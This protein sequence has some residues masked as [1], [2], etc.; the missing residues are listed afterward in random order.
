M[1][2][3]S[4]IMSPGNNRMKV[5]HQWTMRGQARPDLAVLPVY[6]MAEAATWTQ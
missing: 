3:E 6:F 5:E 2:L 4:A 1:T